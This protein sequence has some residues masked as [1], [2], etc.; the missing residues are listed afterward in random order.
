MRWDDSK[1]ERLDKAIREAF[2]F[3]KVAEEW[4]VWFSKHN[5]KFERFPSA[6]QEAAAC[7]RASLDLSKALSELRKT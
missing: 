3:L 4:S 1:F 2:R 6:S 7:K 5:E